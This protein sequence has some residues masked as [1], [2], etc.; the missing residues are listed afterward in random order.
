LIEILVKKGFGASLI[1]PSKHPLPL[2][3]RQVEVCKTGFLEM[4]LV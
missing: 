4:L 1:T 2:G 3:E